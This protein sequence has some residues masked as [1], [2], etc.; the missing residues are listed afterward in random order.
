MMPM[1]PP[2]SITLCIS[3]DGKLRQRAGELLRVDTAE[4]DGTCVVSLLAP[5]FA[6]SHRLSNLH[7]PSASEIS[8]RSKLKAL[9]LVR[10]CLVRE[11][12]KRSYCFSDEDAM[13]PMPRMPVKK[14]WLLEAT[15]NVWL[16][17]C[18]AEG[19]C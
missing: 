9:L 17:T 8:R 19:E 7:I 12:M 18:A 11:L 10:P 15:P 13:G 1:Y 6:S 4:N 16:L 2:I 3:G 5:C 14:P